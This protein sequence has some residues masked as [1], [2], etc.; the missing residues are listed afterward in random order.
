MDMSL[1]QQRIG[2][3]GIVAIQWFAVAAVPFGVARRFPRVDGLALTIAAVIVGY[4]FYTGYRAWNRGW[5][6]RFVLRVVVPVCLFALS[7]IAV[8]LS[9]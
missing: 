1:V 2:M 8:G 9:S 5:K 7:S 6:T 4:C 3:V